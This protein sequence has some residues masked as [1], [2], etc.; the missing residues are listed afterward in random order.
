MTGRKGKT[1]GMIVAL[2]IILNPQDLIILNVGEN[3]LDF[4]YKQKGNW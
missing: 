1:S 4:G 3:D 2:I